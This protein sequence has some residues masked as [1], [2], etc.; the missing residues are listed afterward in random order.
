MKNIIFI[1]IFFFLSY[2]FCISISANDNDINTTFSYAPVF[3]NQNIITHIDKVN[4]FF[5]LERKNNKIIFKPK[6]TIKEISKYYQLSVFNILDIYGGI[7]LKDNDKIFKKL[8]NF[9]IDY[10]IGDDLKQKKFLFNNFRKENIISY[11]KFNITNKLSKRNL[12]YLI[13]RELNIRDDDNYYSFHNN[14]FRFHKRFSENTLN[15]N[16]I[17]VNFTDNLLISNYS[18]DIDFY[19]KFSFWD[20]KDKFIFKPNYLINNYLINKKIGLDRFSGR[21]YVTDKASHSYEYQPAQNRLIINLNPF[22][23]KLINNKDIILEEFVI[24]K[25]LSENKFNKKNYYSFVKNFEFVEEK[26]CRFKKNYEIINFCRNV[27]TSSNEVEFEG[28][29]FSLINIKKIQ[30]Y[31]YYN[32]E[33]NT[34]FENYNNV[35]Y[36]LPKNINVKNY[37]FDEKDF[38]FIKKMNVILPKFLQNKVYYTFHDYIDYFTEVK[39]TS[40]YNENLF[41][42]FVNH[43]STLINE[44]NESMIINSSDCK[45]YDYFQ[46]NNENYCSFQFLNSA[47]YE[48]PFY[49]SIPYS[50]DVLLETNNLQEIIDKY[51]ITDFK[52]TEFQFNTSVQDL[53]FFAQTIEKIFYKKSLLKKEIKYYE[54]DNI[55]INLFYIFFFVI[56]LTVFIYK[57]TN[58]N[59]TSLNSPKKNL[60]LNINQKLALLSILSS[61][62]LTIRVF[63]YNKLVFDTAQFWETELLILSYLLNFYFFLYFTFS[64]LVKNNKI[65]VDYMLIITVILLFSLG[66]YFVYLTNISFFDLFNI[67]GFLILIILSLKNLFLLNEKQPN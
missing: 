38:Y 17:I 55:I 52:L 46:L 23:Q 22:F 7:L 45:V 60:S 56:I 63:N 24:T 36:I 27:S 44:A 37:L 54:K 3:T 16:K 57:K 43:Y 41:N 2:F 25:P 42:N 65:L 50:I 28:N 61:A 20:I 5:S 62:F 31:F 51:K 59:I 48:H 47:L 49:F 12:T 53:E 14:K 21:L 30:S 6:K 15:F 39:N 19:I 29:M 8:D 35:N 18:K 4:K 13:K 11:K 33:F 34:K 58:K 64:F 1:C 66:H 32:S 67:F 9:S 40:K 10:Y 26:N